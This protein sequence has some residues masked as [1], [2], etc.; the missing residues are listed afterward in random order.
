MSTL[1]EIEDR[2]NTILE[3]DPETGEIDEQNTHEQDQ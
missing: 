2:F 1:Y 3:G